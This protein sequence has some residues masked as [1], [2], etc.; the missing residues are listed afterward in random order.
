VPPSFAAAQ[1]SKRPK[2][3]KN[4]QFRHRCANFLRRRDEM[5]IHNSVLELIG[6]TPMVKAQRMDTGP[7][8]NENVVLADPLTA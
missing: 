7:D 2:L 1:P 6:N 3:A 8:R 5:T 4:R